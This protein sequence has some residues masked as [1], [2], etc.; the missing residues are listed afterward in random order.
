MI[1]A[2]T[3]VQR[4]ARWFR[5]IQIFRNVFR[6]VEAWGQRCAASAQGV[7]DLTRERREAVLNPDEARARAAWLRGIAKAHLDAERADVRSFRA[8]LS[9]RAIGAFDHATWLRSLRCE[10]GDLDAA[11]EAERG[12]VFCDRAR[13]RFLPVEQY[14]VPS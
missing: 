2:C 14:S 7:V 8:Q 1:P 12:A 5:P 3:L 4:L 11:L 10:Q 13:N 9:A 6:L